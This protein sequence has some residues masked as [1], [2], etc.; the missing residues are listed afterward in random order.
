[1]YCSKSEA[2][3]SVQSSCSV[4]FLFGILKNIIAALREIWFLSD[5]DHF[6]KQQILEQIFDQNEFSFNSLQQ[7]CLLKVN[8]GNVHVT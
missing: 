4:W 3:S 6:L 2:S 7:F 1:M 5:Q 8:S